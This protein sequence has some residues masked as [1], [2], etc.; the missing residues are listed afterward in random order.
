[1]IEANL[2]IDKLKIVADDK[3]P[4]LRQPLETLADEVIMKAGK[5]ISAADVRDADVL[6]VRT[7]TICN[8]HLL[9]GSSVR[10]VLTATI[11]FDHLDT[12]YLNASGI[13]WHNCPGCNATSVAQ[14]V[15]NSLW[16]LQ[17]ERAISLKDCTLGIIG[18]GNVGTA[19]LE[20]LSEE[21]D[22]SIVKEIL[23][24]DPPREERG[25]PAPLGMRWSSLDEISQKCDI[26]TIHTPLTE[27]GEHPTHHLIDRP[28]LQKL[29]HKAIIINAA[30]GGVVDEAALEEEMDSGRV[31][32]VIIDTWENEPD[33]SRSLLAKA[34]IATPHVAGYS[35]DGKANA[36]RM[37]MEQIC[38]FMHQPMTY[39]IAPPPL[40]E[41]LELAGDNIRRALQLYDPRTDSNHL[42]SEPE[43]FEWWRSNYPLRREKSDN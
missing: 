31:R 33:I 1:L 29:R 43:R 38:R 17:E 6:I 13:E 34:F 28:F 20:A 22:A 40:P 3:I 32:D 5:D 39:T 24:N 9:E 27:G 30:R 35:A 16:A 25:E 10:L 2:T 41:G 15:R 14:Y 23:L 21:G 26:I 19:V 42:K 12:A 11:G 18:A 36:T 7:R 4:Y 37:V 8:R